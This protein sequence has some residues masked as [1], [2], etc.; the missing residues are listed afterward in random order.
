MPLL[1][2]ICLLYGIIF[3]TKMFASCCNCE[4]TTAE[5]RYTDDSILVNNLDNSGR[6]PVLARSEGVV[7]TAYGIQL[8][9][10]SIEVARQNNWGFS[11]ANA[12]SC[13][14]G[15]SVTYSPR[16]SITGIEII[17][18]TPFDDLPAGSDITGR[19]MTAGSTTF[20]PIANFLSTASPSLIYSVDQ[21][22]QTSFLLM[23]PPVTAGIYQ[24]EIRLQLSDGRILSRQ[25]IPIKLT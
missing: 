14:C 15:P 8:Q 17:S 6:E 22:R 7:K 4:D 3:I 18:V 2:K 12:Y 25:T 16:D 5:L 9:I 11:A 1:K 19:F 13:R 24:F 20:G 21:P 10:L 23:Q